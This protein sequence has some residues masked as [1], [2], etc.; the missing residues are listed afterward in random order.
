ML[1]LV[2]KVVRVDRCCLK[3]AEFV[4]A[5]NKSLETTTNE[6]LKASDKGEPLMSEA[7]RP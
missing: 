3:P 6:S 4:K 7:E 1:Q 5:W 2:S